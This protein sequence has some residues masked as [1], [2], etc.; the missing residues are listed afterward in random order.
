MKVNVLTRSY[1][2]S[3]IR[4]GKDGKTEEKLN[5]E[6]GTSKRKGKKKCWG[7]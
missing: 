2:R 4:R 3:N 1:R 6:R 5:K 7:N